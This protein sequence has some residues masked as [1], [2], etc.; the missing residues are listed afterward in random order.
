MSGAWRDGVFLP[1][2][3]GVDQSLQNA[4]REARA[5]GGAQ[6]GVEDVALGVLAAGE[7]LVPPI[8]SAARRV[9][10]GIARRY[11][12]P[13]PAGELIPFCRPGGVREVPRQ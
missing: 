5:R 3:R 13:L 8:L 4:C 2:G 12:G 11:P 9:S 10:T 1:P 6:A 7:G